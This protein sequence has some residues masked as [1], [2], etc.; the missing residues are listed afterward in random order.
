[1]WVPDLGLALRVCPGM[2]PGSGIRGRLLGPRDFS[3]PR[4]RGSRPTQG[5]LNGPRPVGLAR[6]PTRAM[7]LA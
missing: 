4:L 3:L 5:R 7:R 2:A 1:M 6:H